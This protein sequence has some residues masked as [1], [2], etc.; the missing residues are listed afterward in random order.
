MPE[1][2]EFAKFFSSLWECDGPFPW[3]KR[4]ARRLCETGRWPKW[5]TLP[6][7]TGKTACLDIAIYHLATQAH[8][9]LR[10]RSAPARIVFAVNRRIVVDG[11][12]ERMHKIADKL[13]KACKD[14]TDTLHPIAKALQNMAKD[15]RAVPLDVYPLRGGMFTDRAWARTPTQPLVL[16]TTLDQLGSRLLFRG[17]GVSKYARPLH[18]AL[19]ANDALLMLDEA[20]TSKAFSQ[21]LAAIDKFRSRGSEPLH[22]PFHSVQLT[23]TPP[24]DAVDPF[25]LDEEDGQNSILKARIVASKPTKLIRVAGATGKK[26]HTK[27]ATEMVS[28]TNEQLAKGIRHILIV[29]NRV[30]T[31]EKI[32]DK[33]KSSQNDQGRHTAIQLLTGRQRPLDHEQWIDDIKHRMKPDAPPKPSEPLVVVATQCIEVGADYDFDALL[34]E[35]APLDCLRQ[36]MGRLNRTGRSISAAA[37]IFAPEEALEP[38]S[39]DPLYGSSL[40]ETWK[41]LEKAREDEKSNS[42][43]FGV[44]A[45]QAHLTGQDI[46][47]LLAPVADA[48]I[49]MPAHLDL[50]CQTSPAPHAEPSPSLYIHGPDRDCPEVHIVFRADIDNSDDSVANLIEALPPLSTEAATVPLYL[51]QQLWENHDNLDEIT[52]DTGDIPSKNIS[53][54]KDKSPTT[55]IRAWRYWEKEAEKKEAK[56]IKNFDEIRPG[57]FVILPTGS[58]L[59]AKFISSPS[60]DASPWSVDQYERAHLAARDKLRIRFHKGIIEAIKNELNGAG[61]GEEAFRG[62]VDPLLEP[63]DDETRDVMRDKWKNAIP[64]IARL[65]A[66]KLPNNHPWKKIWKHAAEKANQTNLEKWEVVPMPDE[67]PDGVILEYRKRVGSTKW[68]IDPDDLEIRSTTADREVLLEDHSQGVARRAKENGAGLTDTIVSTLSDAGLWHD[69]GKRDPRFQALLQGVSRF[70]VNNRRLLAKSDGG[71]RPNH[72]EAFYDKQSGLPEGFRHELLSTLILSQSESIKNHPERDL[73]LHLTASHHGRCRALAPIIADPEPEPFRA[74]V[75]SETVNYAGTDYPLAHFEAG[76]TRRFWTLTRRFGWWGLPYLE[77]LLRLAD[78]RE[79]A[80]PSP[81]P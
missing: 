22:T 51:M 31:A 40:V 47:P 3:Q 16:T 27:L 11:A 79:S 60:E 12:F 80:S 59:L 64:E 73:L 30:A 69:L 68:P 65:L 71:F 7:G 56:K 67:G 35:L 4:L 23:A 29:A 6:T 75:D 53:S 58:K 61:D 41:F 44:E 77:T 63:D 78:Q 45:F 2:P 76:V 20:H 46:Q 49:L 81:N 52:D 39:D 32:F 37:F 25:E 57:D 36:R 54:E 70:A 17:Y 14:Q 5:I 42:I 10:E 38:K 72:F 13:Q 18:A 26:R 43:D 15:E 48:P 66:N 9:S 55:P 1:L 21:T 74:E 8:L 34:T 62:L 19:L 28:K 24:K 33:L 50:L